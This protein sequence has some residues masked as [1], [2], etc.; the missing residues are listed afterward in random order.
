MWWLTV[1]LVAA[2]WAPPQ[3]SDQ[4]AI[5]VFMRVRDRVFAETVRLPRYTC[6]Q[7]IKR[8]YFQADVDRLKLRGCDAILGARRTRKH[9]LAVGDEDR[10]RLDVAVASGREIHSWAGANRF[11]D[12]ELFD[13]IGWGPSGTGDFRG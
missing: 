12:K 2:G 1:A 5:Q 10:L 4:E 9:D 8:T 3:A 11:E 13:I 7:T 6:V